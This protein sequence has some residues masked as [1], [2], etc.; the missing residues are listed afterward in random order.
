MKSAQVPKFTSRRPSRFASQ[1][2]A[3]PIP[4]GLQDDA[5]LMEPPSPVSG[6]MQ[7]ASSSDMVASQDRI[8]A[9]YAQAI[10]CYQASPPCAHSSLLCTVAINCL[11]AGPLFTRLCHFNLISRQVSSCELLSASCVTQAQ[12]ADVWITATPLCL[13]T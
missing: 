6:S 11:Q 13:C 3:S 10:S 5:D 7:Q 8:L 4:S 12:S 9:G 2:T 1:S